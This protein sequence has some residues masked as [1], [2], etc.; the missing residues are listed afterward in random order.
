[1]IHQFLSKNYQKTV[2]HRQESRQSE[3]F[4]LRVL[5]AY[6]LKRVALLGPGLLRPSE[7]LPQYESETAYSLTVLP[8]ESLSLKTAAR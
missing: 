8:P 5:R 7:I 3:L 2:G 4:F 6:V 1:M